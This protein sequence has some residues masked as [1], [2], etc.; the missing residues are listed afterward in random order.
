MAIYEFHCLSCKTFTEIS[1]S[2][3]ESIPVPCCSSCGLAMT[4]QYT[5]PGVEFKGSGFYSTDNR[6]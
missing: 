4:R 6:K 1:A 2:I 3:K 5:V